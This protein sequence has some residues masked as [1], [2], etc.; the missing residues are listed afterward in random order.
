MNCS[1]LTGARSAS[2][3]SAASTGEL[4]CSTTPPMWVSS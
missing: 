1:P 2:A 3:N 4:V